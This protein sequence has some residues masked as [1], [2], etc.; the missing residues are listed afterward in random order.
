MAAPHK[1]ERYGETWN[2]EE[3]AV[4]QAEIEAVRDFTVVSGGWAWHFMTPPHPEYKH[5]HD[6]KDADLFCEPDR[7]W[8]LFLVL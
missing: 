3:I 5:A 2:A 4:V 6:H 1:I 8:E 7:V